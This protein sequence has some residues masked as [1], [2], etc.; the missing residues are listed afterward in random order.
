MAMGVDVRAEILIARPREE[1]AGYAMD[2]RN[3]P[4]WIGGIQT[5]EILGGSEIRQGTHVTRVARFLGRRIEYVN[6]VVDHSPPA[7]LAMRSVKAP[8]PMEVTYEFEE[9]DGG[10]LARI[11]VRGDAGRFYGLAAPLLSRAVRRS[12]SRDLASLRSLL[13]GQS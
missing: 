3:D 10:T 13:E 11:H 5:A 6:E 12:I 8:F 9:R 2:A 1:V 7:R 4:R